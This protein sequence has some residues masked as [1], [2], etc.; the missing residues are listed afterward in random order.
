[1][2]SSVINPMNDVYDIFKKYI[3]QPSIKNIKGKYKTIRNFRPVTT[4]EVKKVIKDLKANKRRVGAIPIQIL[5]ES[6]FTL[7]YLKK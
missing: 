4:D 1:M 7:E 3:N 6:E 5:K 2:T